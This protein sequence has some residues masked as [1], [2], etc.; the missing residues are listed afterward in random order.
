MRWLS[1]VLFVLLLAGS[2]LARFDPF[3]EAT[4]VDRPGAQIPL[5][6]DLLD[7]DGRQTTLAKLSGGKP[8]L[9]APVL[10]NCP[11]ICGVTLSGLLDAVSKQAL[12][13]GRDFTLVAFGIDPKE[14]VAD[15]QHAQSELKKRFPDLVGTGTH[16]TVAD[17]AVV[18]NVTT[19]LGYHFAFDPK[20][21]QYAHVAAVAVVSP[22]GKLTRWLYGVSPDPL[23]VKLALTEAG[24]GKTGTWGDQLLLLCYHY[25]PATGQY[26]SRVMTAL[27]FGGSAFVVI[28]LALVGRAFLRKRKPSEVRDV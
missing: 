2:A 11:N 7:E 22:K 27:R 21:G 8:L 1:A 17:P 6:G 15:A 4:I 18:K 20:V 9:L 5:G 16:S 3:K 26:T 28:G 25:D 23:D 24:Q 19:A 12:R 10:H 13:P 14:T